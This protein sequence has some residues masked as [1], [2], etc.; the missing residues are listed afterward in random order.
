MSMSGFNASAPAK[1]K[2]STPMPMRAAFSKVPGEPAATQM[3]GCG[4][5]TG[6]GNTFWRRGIEKNLPSK[7]P[8]SSGPI[9][10]TI[11]GSA[12]SNMSRV[13]SIESMPNPN[14]SVDDDPRPVPNSNRPGA[15]WSS[16]ATFSATR[17]GWQTG[18]VMLMM[19]EP[20]WM[21]SVM[22]SAYAIHASLA[23]RCEYS[24]RKWCSVTQT[25]LNPERSAACTTSSSAR[26]TSCSLSPAARRCSGWYMPTKTPNSTAAPLRVVP[27]GCWLETDTT[28]PV[29]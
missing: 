23:E 4:C 26:N 24:S 28:S 15:S 8:Y 10:F 25:Y 1:L 7:G 3:G 2:H 17:P 12:S 11:S 16:I 14:T 13:V 9:I 27:Y 6:F 5:V 22:A 18:G 19:P 29:M 21:L 20:M